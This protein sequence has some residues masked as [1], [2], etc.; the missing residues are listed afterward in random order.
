MCANSMSFWCY[1]NFFQIYEFLSESSLHELSV[2]IFR[3]KSQKRLK[4]LNIKKILLKFNKI[5]LKF[6]FLNFCAFNKDVVQENYIAL[7]KFLWFIQP[8]L[9]FKIKRNWSFFL[10]LSVYFYQYLVKINGKTIQL[11]YALQWFYK[12]KDRFKVFF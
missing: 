10:L 1:I 9:L 2:N 7:S 4:Y 12:V 6:E 11:D 5:L 8:I 3:T